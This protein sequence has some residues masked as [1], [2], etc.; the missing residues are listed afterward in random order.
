MTVA[1]EAGRCMHGN[2]RSVCFVQHCVRERGTLH[3]PPNPDVAEVERY[4]REGCRHAG[5]PGALARA[6]EEGVRQKHG[7]FML[8][9]YRID[10]CP[11][12]HEMILVARSADPAPLVRNGASA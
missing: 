10:H 3:V 9:L 12:C 1:D 11:T 5:V 2:L 8:G 4:N 6:D 7:V